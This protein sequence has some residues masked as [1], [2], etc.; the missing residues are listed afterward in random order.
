[1]LKELDRFEDSMVV[2]HGDHGRYWRPQDRGALAEY[3]PLEASEMTRDE[4]DKKPSDRWASSAVA[5]RASSL[6]WIKFP[7]AKQPETS[8][9]PAQ[10]IDVAPTILKHFG[11]VGEGFQGVPVQDLTPETKR[12]HR[13]QGVNCVPQNGRPDT[14]STYE[15]EGDRWIHRETTATNRSNY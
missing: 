9:K 6:L 10:I 8:P 3:A 13:F 2:V 15:R 11:L 12:S 4:A 14:M 1:R 7:G 5:V